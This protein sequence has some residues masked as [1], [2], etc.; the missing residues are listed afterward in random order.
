VAAR[1]PWA[2]TRSVRSS[3]EGIVRVLRI[4]VCLGLLAVA[5]ASCGGEQTLRESAVD[6]ELPPSGR[7]YRLLDDAKRTAVA[8]GCR[9]RAAASSGGLAA[10]ELRAIDPSALREHLDTAFTV[11]V[12][13]RRPVADVCREA[14]PFLTPG[15]QVR[16]D[17]AVEDGR[18]GF[19]VRTN[20]QK[21][22]TIGGTVTPPTAGARVTARREVGPPVQRR[23]P[24][25][26][27][28]AFRLPSVGL[29]RVADNT[30]TVTIHAP[31]HA[32]RKVLFTA[33]CLD[34]LAGAPPPT[35]GSSR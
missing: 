16:F 20:S 14:I 1:L 6:A 24:V 11:I 29:R 31:P 3:R 23:G 34:C 28:G 30:F 27:D 9:D 4:R 18:G 21:P 10:R 35:A 2:Q 32:P 7:A 19:L 12:E 8:A 5:V 13:Q 26:T 15:L 25:A 22:L 17:G 33:L